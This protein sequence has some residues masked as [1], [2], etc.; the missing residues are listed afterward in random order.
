MAHHKPNVVYGRLN[1]TN[2]R[3]TILMPHSLLSW[4]APEFTKY[5][6]TK[7][8]YVVFVLIA[9][10]LLFLAFWFKTFTTIIF[11]FLAIFL[12]IIYSLKE[13][14]IINFSIT[15]LGIEIEKSLHQFPDIESF[16]IFYDPPEIKEICFK[17]KKAI[18]PHIFVPL[19]NIDPN[20]VR[21]ILLEYLPEKKQEESLADNIARRLR[22]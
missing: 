4:Q 13:P 17:T 12:V 6:K 5:K 15:A 20:K 16:W 21:K 10:G 14:R 18:F 8:W 9:A 7:T 1:H 3:F 11:L 2:F 19:S 22:F